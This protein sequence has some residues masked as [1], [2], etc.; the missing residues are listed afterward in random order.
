M[1]IAAGLVRI[2]NRGFF[3]I[4]GQTLLVGGA[5]LQ[6]AQL[7]LYYRHM[8]FSFIEM[9]WPLLL[10]WIGLLVTVR[11]FFPKERCQKTKGQPSS[12]DSSGEWP[13]RE[14]QDL[15]AVPICVG[16][17]NDNDNYEGEN[18]G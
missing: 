5:L 2:W 15:D 3:N 8:Y 9:W 1:L 17:K 4:W 18:N 14:H 10:I 13:K 11:A 16:S 6:L 12:D 7:Q